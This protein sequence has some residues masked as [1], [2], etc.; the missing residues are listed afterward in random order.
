MYDFH[1]HTFL[2][3]GVLSPIELIRRASVRGYKGMAVTDHVGIGNLEL[4]VKTLVKDCAMATKRWDILALPGVEVTHVPKD[5]IDL[6]AR[7]AKEMGAK[8]VTVH[9][10]T[11]VE[12][13]EPGT[14]EAA[15]RSAYV[16]ILAH[17]GLIS[18]EDARLA[19]ENHVFLEVSARKGH[20]FTNGHV[21]QVARKAGALLVL[22]SD[23]HE[24]EDLLTLE[25]N[26]RIAKGAGLND[27][28]THALL[29]LNPQSLLD[30]LG[31]GPSNA[32]RSKAVTS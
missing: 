24:P 11:I 26:Y 25:M 27:E 31:F 16:D 15:I 5:D 22:D 19:A 32:A 29:E 30:R 10:E 20:S 14:N 1:T 18:Y 13:V 3:D 2:S 8:V 6:L 7:T 12:P 17:P 28:E 4:V 9:G 21:V 23:A